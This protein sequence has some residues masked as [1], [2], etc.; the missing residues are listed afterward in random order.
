MAR[1]GNPGDAAR[2]T[3]A[4]NAMLSRHVPLE[5]T[6]TEENALAHL[7]FLRQTRLDQALVYLRE[8]LGNDEF[9]RLSRAGAKLSY[10]EAVDLAIVTL[11]VSN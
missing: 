11:D 5:S 3:G 7:E 8:V 1:L 9:E 2:L 6:F 4:Y 10:D